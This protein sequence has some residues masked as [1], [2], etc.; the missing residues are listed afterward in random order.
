MKERN[1]VKEG[2]KRGEEDGREVG[3]M[4][5]NSKHFDEERDSQAVL[6]RRVHF[7]KHLYHTE[8]KIECFPPERMHLIT[9]A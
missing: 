9:S 5:T 6:L 8:T 4:K 1:R 7:F 2:E 3:R